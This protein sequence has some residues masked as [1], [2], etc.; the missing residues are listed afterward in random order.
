LRRL[1]S[2]GRITVGPPKPARR[3]RLYL[4]R[5]VLRR[6]CRR[7]RSLCQRRDH[8]ELRE[9]MSK[10]REGLPRHGASGEARFVSA[11]HSMKHRLGTIEQLARRATCWAGSSVAFGVAVLIVLIWIITGPIF[12][13]SDTW[14]LV[15]NTGT[16][17]VTFLMVFLIQRT[18]NKDSLAIHL[19]LNELVASLQGASNRLINIEDLSERDIE[20]LHA[21]YGHLVKLARASG[22][23]QNSHSIEEAESRHAAKS[24]DRARTAAKR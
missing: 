18:Q 24:P 6:L 22:E 5:E 7:L 15:I 23:L 4:L 19:K 12:G 1:L 9:G 13:F 3:A 21:H 10:L 20:V 17:I 16:T 8:G 2:I 14:Q 11:E